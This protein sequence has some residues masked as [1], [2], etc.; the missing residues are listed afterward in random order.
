MEIRAKGEMMNVLDEIFDSHEKLI[1]LNKGTLEYGFSWKEEEGIIIYISTPDA[2]SSYDFVTNNISMIK[3]SLDFTINNIEIMYAGKNEL[4]NALKVL[5]HALIVIF[6]GFEPFSSK[7]TLAYADLVKMLPTNSAHRV[8]S[9]RQLGDFLPIGTNQ[10]KIHDWYRKSYLAASSTTK[11]KV[12]KAYNLFQDSLSQATY[13]SILKRY[14]LSSDTLIP[15]SRQTQYFEDVYTLL[16]DEIFV[17]IG[18]FSGDTLEIYNTLAEGVFKEYH[19]F[20]PDPNILPSLQKTLESLPQ[21]IT[22]KVTHYPCAVS[23]TKT[24][25]SFNTSTIANGTIIEDIEHSPLD[26]LLASTRA[27]LIKIDVDGYESFVLLGART[28]LKTH[29]PVV[30]LCVYH[31]PFDLWELPLLVEKLTGNNYR[32]YLRAYTDTLEYVC[33]CVPEERVSQNWK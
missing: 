6:V 30:A 33:Y 13:A 18:G 1:A 25:T 14:L 16:K 31:Y 19:L 4:E 12:E 7:L 8:I 9:F 23:H 27:S 28:I 21:A 10:T 26:E 22:N 20:E 24:K 5:P 17:D 32:Y 15:V 11:K 29:R 2:Q 3:P